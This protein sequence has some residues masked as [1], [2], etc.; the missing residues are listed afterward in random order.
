MCTANIL[1]S[2]FIKLAMVSPIFFRLPLV[3]AEGLV[4]SSAGFY[5]NTKGQ[6]GK[7]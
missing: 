5:E 4:L 3:P 6:V 7:H 2:H 1:P